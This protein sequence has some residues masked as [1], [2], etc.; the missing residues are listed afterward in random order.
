MNLLWWLLVVLGV[1]MAF[2]V[3]VFLILILVDIWIS[4]IERDESPGSLTTK[5]DWKA[6]LILALIWE[7]SMFSA[8]VFAQKSRLPAPA[9][10]PTS[11]GDAQVSTQ[12]AQ[13]SPAPTSP[14]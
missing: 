1:H 13:P 4:T 2:A 9:D 10:P 8:L 6:D 12:S 3:V 14:Q 5:L 7:Y 11:V